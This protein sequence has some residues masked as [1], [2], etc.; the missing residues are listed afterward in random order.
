MTSFWRSPTTT[1]KLRFFSC[2][3][4]RISAGMRESM[5]F[6]GILR[7]AQA[8]APP[9]PYSSVF[10]WRRQLYNTKRVARCSWANGKGATPI[11]GVVVRLAARGS[12]SSSRRGSFKGSEKIIVID[13]RV[14]LALHPST[15]AHS[16]Q[17]KPSTKLVIQKSGCMLIPHS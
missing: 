6:F 15:R 5:A 14:A 9:L 11:A 10:G 7:A 8:A 13:N 16:V 3:P 4:F 1:K 2:A 17:S 12:K